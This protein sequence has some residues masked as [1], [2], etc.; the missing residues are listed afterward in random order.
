MNIIK[1]LL[2]TGK[3]WKKFSG[4]IFHTEE[5]PNDLDYSEKKIIVIGSSATSATTIPAMAE[6]LVMLNNASKNPYLL[7][8]INCGNRRACRKIEKI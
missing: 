7:Q 3:I 1:A 2:R 5:W 8:N 4:K 6:K